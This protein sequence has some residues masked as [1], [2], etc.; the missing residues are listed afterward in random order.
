[1]KRR[2]FLTAAIAAPT[3]SSSVLHSAVPS[4]APLRVSAFGGFFQDEFESKICRKFTQETGIP[5]TTISQGQGDD[6][7]FPLVRSV[8]GGLD[9][10]DLTFLDQVGLQLEKNGGKGDKKFVRGWRGQATPA[11]CRCRRSCRRGGLLH[12]LLIRLKV[13]AFHYLLSNPASVCWSL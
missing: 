6:W 11:A 5:V 3:L 10:M 7:L 8:R 1:M 13:H 9:P 4:G 12:V 2:H